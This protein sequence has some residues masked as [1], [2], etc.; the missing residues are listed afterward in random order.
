MWKK[1]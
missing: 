1:I